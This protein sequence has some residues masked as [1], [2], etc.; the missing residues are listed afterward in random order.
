MTPPEITQCASNIEDNGE[1]AWCTNKGV[2]CFTTAFVDAASLKPVLFLSLKN[3]NVGIFPH[4]AVHT[5]KAT[6]FGALVRHTLFHGKTTPL[7][8]LNASFFDK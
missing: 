4:A 2:H 6:F 3:Y 8:P 7:E 1:I 5:K